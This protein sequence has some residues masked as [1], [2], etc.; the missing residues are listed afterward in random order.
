MIY[1]CEW[2]TK[3]SKGTI[4]LEAP[5]AKDARK[6]A[7]AAFRD[8]YGLR[9]HIFAVERWVPGRERKKSE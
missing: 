5:T 6:R 2:S 4:G 3:R 7:R 9:V 8:G 1:T